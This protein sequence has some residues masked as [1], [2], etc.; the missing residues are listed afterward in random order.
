MT[1]QF[2]GKLTGRKK[3]TAAC[4]VEFD[5]TRALLDDATVKPQLPDGTYQ[6]EVRGTSKRAVRRD[7]VW[8]VSAPKRVARRKK[9]SRK[10][11]N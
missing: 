1:W 6:L 5:S 4:V 7:G 9:P 8:T 3:L 2:F 10:N 11:S